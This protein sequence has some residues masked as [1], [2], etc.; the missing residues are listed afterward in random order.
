MRI[1]VRLDIFQ[2]LNRQIFV[3]QIGIHYS[4]TLYQV[5]VR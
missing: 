4:V 3:C 1:I 2:M 5:W